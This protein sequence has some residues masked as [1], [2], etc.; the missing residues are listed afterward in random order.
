MDCSK[1]AFKVREQLRGFLGIF[2][3]RFSK[4]VAHFIGQMVYGI[5]AAQDVK[6]SQ[7]GRE[8]HESIPIGKTENRL[9]RNL[10]L[11]GLDE[12]LHDCLLDYSARRIREDTLV[13]I[14]PSDIQKGYARKMPY[15]AKVWDGSKGGV[16]DNL[17]YSGC[18]AVACESGARRMSPL[19]FRLWSSEAPGFKSE[20]TEVEAVV[21]A[22]AGK[23]EGRGIYVYD[24]GGDRNGLFEA[25]LDKGLRFVVR[26]VGNRNL[27][28]RRKARLAEKLAGKCRMRHRTA[29]TFLSHNREVRVQ[30]GFGVLDVRLPDRPGTPLRMVV[31]KGF[32]QK[33]MML[34]TNLEGTESYRSLWQVVEGYITRWR[35]EE[36]I[37]FIKQAYSLE[38]MRLLNYARLKNMAA[39]A[40]CAA[41]FA[42]TWMGLGEKLTILRDHVIDISQRIHEVPEA[43]YYAIADGIRRLFTRFGAGWKRERERPPDPE[44]E[45]QMLLDLCLAPG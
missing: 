6:L 44:E 34:L 36:A 13:I 20:N 17:G 37:R 31:V 3:P 40:V 4:P 9:S 8:L 10:A 45:R 22:I 28:W 27:V 7:I 33:P 2:S 32:G 25:F 35:V 42:A 16:G 11:E 14:D 19:M 23:T 12:A 41:S 24:R 43:F 21:D 39:L 26:L 5:Q 15:L 18:M 30:I 29:V 38:D 1:T